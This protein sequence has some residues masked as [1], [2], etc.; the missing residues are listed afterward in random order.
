MLL[1]KRPSA[2]TQQPPT[3]KTSINQKHI[4]LQVHQSHSDLSQL[5]QSSNVSL[6]VRYL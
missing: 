4:I 2:V 5:T 6:Y 1:K 3:D